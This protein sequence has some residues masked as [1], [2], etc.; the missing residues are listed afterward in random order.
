MFIRLI[1]AVFILLTNSCEKKEIFNSGKPIVLVSVP[2]YTY[3]VKKIAQDTVT[4][5]SLIP[6]GANPHVY[7]AAPKE[8]QSHQNAAIWVRLGE[9]F[10]K[11]VYQVFKQLHKPVQI[12]DVAQ[13]IE[14][15]S[16]CEDHGLVT[17]EHHCH[18]HDEGKDL[19]I[20][21]SPKLAKLQAQKIAEALIALLPEQ[22][23]F[24]SANLQNFL[25][26]LDEMDRQ[27]AALLAPM[28]GKAILVS[29]PAFGYFCQDYHLVQLSIE[30][31]GKE[32]LPQ[33]VTEIL[34][35]A[36]RYAVQAVLVEPQYS[37][38]GAELIAKRLGLPTHSVDPYS[39]NYLENLLAIAQ[40]ISHG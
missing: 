20:W 10:D 2:P 16:F 40:V 27:I 36:K 23:E 12:V 25:E 39:E 9:S 35:S 1:L 33:H 14:L 32:P 8:V 21:L 5:Q 26:E 6:A 18:T 3:F 24:F 38:K 22:R 7:E 19:H 37:N 15:L 11:K 13:G 30:M 4:V 34:A 29:H 28:E 31:E 17:D